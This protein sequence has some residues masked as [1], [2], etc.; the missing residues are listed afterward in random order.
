MSDKTLYLREDVYFEPLFNQ[1]YC[2]SMLIPPVTAARYTVSTHRRI[3]KSF[4]NNYD[5]H[6]SAVKESVVTGG[7]FLNCTKE[8]VGDVQALID[9]IDRD[10]PDVV[11]IANAIRDVDNMLVEHTNGHSIEYF[12]EKLPAELSGY[13]ELVMDLQH[14]PTYRLIEPLLYKS[15]YY[16]P[17][18]QALS[19]GMWSKVDDRP[20][21]LSTPRLPDNNHLEVK[22]SF[23][24]SLVDALF[25]AREFPVSQQCVES[26]FADVKIRGGLDYRELF[27]QQT[28]NHPYTPVDQGVRV[29]YMGHAGFMLESRNTCVL[30]DPVIASRGE[31][32]ANDVCSFSQIPPNIDC[33]CLTHNHQDHVNIE[34]LLQLRY[35]TKKILVPKNNGGS[36]AD[37]SLKL[38]LQ[39]LQ[40]DVVEMDELE[41]FTLTGGQITSIP[42]LGEHGDLNVRSKTAWLVELEGKKCFFGADSA[43]PDINLYR[44]M[45]DLLADL[46]VYAIGMECVGAPYTWLYG[47]LHTKVVAKTIKESRRLNGSDC[48][49]ALAV[50]ELLKPARV[51]LYALGMEPWYKYFMGLEYDGDSK[52]IVESNRMLQ[53]CADRGIHA[54]TMYGKH[55]TLLK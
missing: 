50:V 11:A 10:L 36:L 51:Y 6:I 28:S 31:S 47:A 44:H 12:Y 2:W 13:I 4:V 3:M 49:Q 18:L 17:E 14:R 15:S 39:Q 9:H 30:I 21:V 42:F 48:E 43:N 46:D 32:F 33:I 7:D 22:Q 19:F 34:S 24:A 20:F 5:L 38:M 37:P 41:V 52:Q 16:K 26:W 29:Q 53:A 54:E 35:K 45:R 55:L 40:F 8:Q 1:W 27:T 25:R 23:N